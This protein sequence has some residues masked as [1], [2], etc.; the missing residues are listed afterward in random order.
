MEFIAPIVTIEAL[1]DWS[2]TKYV[3]GHRKEPMYKLIGYFFYIALLELFQKAIEFKGLGWANSA[4]DGW[5]NLVTGLMA[6]FIIGERPCMRELFGMM[7]ISVGLFFLGTTGTAN[8][9]RGA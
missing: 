7:L 3:Q 4:W 6:I 2:F 1:G 8:Y 9:N 5:S